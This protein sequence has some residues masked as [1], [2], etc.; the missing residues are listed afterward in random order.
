MFE[1]NEKKEINNVDIKV[2]SLLSTRKQTWVRVSLYTIKPKCKNSEQENKNR[3]KNRGRP[4]G[5]GQAKMS[6]ETLRKYPYIDLKIDINKIL[7]STATFWARHINSHI[8]FARLAVYARRSTTTGILSNIHGRKSVGS[9]F[10]SAY[11][12]YDEFRLTN[13]LLFANE[14]LLKKLLWNW[15]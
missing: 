9:F 15:M 3:E 12:L 13:I 1:I 11:S 7:G 2:F 5:R 6:T 14:I 8:V 10:C 4:W